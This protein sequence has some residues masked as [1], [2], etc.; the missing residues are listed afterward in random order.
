MH[1][2]LQDVDLKAFREFLENVDGNTF[3]SPSTFLEWVSQ[4][5]L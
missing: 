2:C 3:R 4:S 1:E 5:P